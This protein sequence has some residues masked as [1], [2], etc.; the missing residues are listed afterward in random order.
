MDS[1][2][3]QTITALKIVRQQRTTGDYY[4]SRRSFSHDRHRLHDRRKLA[5]GRLA[6]IIISLRRL[7][8]CESSVSNYP[9]SPSD[10]ASHRSF[11]YYNRIVGNTSVADGA[12][13]LH[14]IT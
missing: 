3:Y 9:I 10:S 2:F 4:A 13:I 8:N 1:Y 6:V 7:T 14:M 5:E 11:A 12:L